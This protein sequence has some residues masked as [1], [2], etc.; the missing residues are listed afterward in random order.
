MDLETVRLFGEDV[1]AN[2]WPQQW[3]GDLPYNELVASN[4]L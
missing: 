1:A 4:R 2:P 3:I